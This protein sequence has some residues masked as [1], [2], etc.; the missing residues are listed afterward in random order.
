[1]KDI[2]PL[3]HGLK[4]H[5]DAHVGEI[6][7]RI[8]G[9]KTDWVRQG[10]ARSHTVVP[11]APSNSDICVVRALIELHERFPP[12]LAIGLKNA[13]DTRMGGSPSAG[14]HSASLLRSA[15][16]ENGPDP[17]AFSLHSLRSGGAT[18]IYLAARDVE[19]VAMVGRWRAKFSPA[20][21]RG[22]RQVPDGL[23]V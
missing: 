7:I 1:M 19:L 6:S 18:A 16:F 4:T 11:L 8:S 14:A 3:P 9:P 2:E 15:V 22:C 13:F 20:Y 5:W 12:K 10:C 21:L 17:G 23:R